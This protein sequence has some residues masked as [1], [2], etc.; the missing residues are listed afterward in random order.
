MRCTLTHLLAALLAALVAL[1]A[2]RVRSHDIETNTRSQTPSAEPEAKGKEISGNNHPATELALA[3]LPRAAATAPAPPEFAD[4][5]PDEQI[6]IWVYKSAN[7]SVVNITT[8]SVQM[9]DF[10]FFATPRAGTGS[11]S[12]LDKQGHI[13]TNFHV[14]EGAQ[15]IAVTF[16]DSTT[17]EAKLVGADPNNDLAVLKVD[18]PPD[19]LAP[20]PWGDSNK[21]QVGMRVFAIGNPFGL[22]RT[23]TTGIVSSLNRSLRTDNNR[24]I[25]GIIQTD[26]AINPGN[27]GGPV[28]NREG[29]LV[30]ITTAIVSRAGQHSGVGLAIPASTARRIV[31][32]L[33]QFGRVKRPDCGIVSVNEL[34]RGLLIARLE[35]DGPA[36]RAGLRGPAV[37]MSQRGGLVWRSIDRSKADLITA[38]DGAAVRTIDDLLNHVES[39][40]PG[41]KV[42]FSIIRDG[43][44]TEVTVVLDETK[45]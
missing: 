23:L 18:A 40:Q 45:E 15:R 1:A 4:L 19:I 25:K 17:W 11:G 44:K 9:D 36:D 34:D 32:D 30:G 41:D 27:S 24:L 16:F 2:V 5:S 43:K 13:L 12:V 35:R 37:V 39:K 8:R 38:V 14:V 21:L 31:D 42:I 7:R 20:V 22:D 6:N 3:Q 28:L 29:E 26:A 33:I 10:L